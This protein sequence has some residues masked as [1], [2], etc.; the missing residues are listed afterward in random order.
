[1]ITLSNKRIT[2][3]DKANKDEKFPIA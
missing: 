3:M 2:D 1:M